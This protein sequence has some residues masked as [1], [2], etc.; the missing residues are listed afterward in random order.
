MIRLLVSAVLLVLIAWALDLGQVVA[1]LR[2]L[3]APWVL[4][5]LFIS[6]LQVIV[7]AWRW[8]Y[9]SARLGVHMTMKQA[10]GEYYLGNLLNQLLPGG[11]S[12]DATRAWRHARVSE[13]GGPA[14]RA[15][16]LERASGQVVMTVVAL[17]SF[18]SLPFVSGSARTLALLGG[19]VVVGLVFLAQRRAPSSDSML[20]RLWSDT[21]GALLERRALTVQLLSAGLLVASYITVYVIAARAIGVE[22][23]LGQLLPLVAPVLMTMLIPVTVAGWGVREGAA[24]ALW[25]LV[26]LTP[27]EGV[28]ISVAYGL[29][30][31]VSATPGL[32]MLP[33]VWSGTPEP[34]RPASP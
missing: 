26:G 22:T 27:E 13:R 9:T 25:A 6:V 34:S 21:R 1:R 24:A 23:P 18:L 15:V 12:G 3:R 19:G 10:L 16:V 33:R 8:R 2:D 11:I 17:I 14:V 30:V 5:A 7:L 32:L 29:V 31:L 20:G 28:S 4:L